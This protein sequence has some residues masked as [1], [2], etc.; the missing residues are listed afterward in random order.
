MILGL[1]SIYNILL[2]GLSLY[3]DM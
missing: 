3:S 2:V 1:V